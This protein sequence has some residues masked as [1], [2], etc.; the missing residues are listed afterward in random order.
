MKEKLLLRE[1]PAD[2]LPRERLLNFGEKALSDQ[3]LL[4]IVLRT[5]YASQN[6]MELAGALLQHFSSLY[7]I[8][9]ASLQELKTVKGIGQI[10]ALELK[11]VLELGWRIQ[12]AQQPKIGRVTSSYDLAQQLILQQKDWHQEHL[13]ALYL[14]TKNEIIVKKTIFIGSLNQ[15]IAHPREIFRFGVRCSAARIL[16]T[17]NHPSGNPTPSSN[18]LDFTARLI[19]CGEMLGIELLDHIITGEKSYISLREE[20]FWKK[21]N[22]GT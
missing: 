16:I 15:S 7:E 11:A 20:G 17:H 9:Q 14:N 19:K 13:R 18:D 4:A 1:M 6:V 8:K 3:E 21:I 10:K 2:S 12:Q 5:G 22:Q